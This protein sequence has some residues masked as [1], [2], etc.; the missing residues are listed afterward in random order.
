MKSVEE[1]FKNK[2]SVD[3]HGCWVWQASLDKDGYA[4]FNDQ[5]YK[6]VRAHRFSYEI[7]FQKI[8]AGMVIDHL[9][10]NRRCVNPEHLEP[11]TNKE[12]ILRGD[13]VKKICQHGVAHTRCKDGCL[14]TYHREYKRKKTSVKKLGYN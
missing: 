12:N 2:Y 6:T 1:R 9:C 13:R 14:T 10:K 3:E 4:L 8:A 7:T 11:V 5:N